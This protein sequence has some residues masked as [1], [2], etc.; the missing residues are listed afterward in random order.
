MVIPTPYEML[1]GGDYYITI[2]PYLPCSL[3]II[4]ANPDRHYP[5]V[6]FNLCKV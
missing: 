1:V 4:E 3:A 5:Q 2:M 6:N